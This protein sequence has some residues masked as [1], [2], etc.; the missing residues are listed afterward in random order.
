M[1]AKT[2]RA[3]RWLALLLTA[4]GIGV[5]SL[6][7]V[8]QPES[9][10][11]TAPEGV[12][13]TEVAKLQEKIS[14]QEND[15]D[16]SSTAIVFLTSDDELDIPALS[17]IAE[18]LGGPL[19][20]AESGRAAMVPVSIEAG[21]AT[22]NNEEVLQLRDDIAAELPE[23]VESQVTGP[24]A[25]R[26]DLAEVFQGANFLLLAVTAGIVAVL[27]IITYRSPIL[28]LLPLLVIAVA[29]RATNTVFTYLLDAMDF[30]WDESVAGI[31]S[32]LVFG[33]GTNY[34]LLLISRYRDELTL[35][36]DR[37]EAMAKAWIPTL[38]TVSASAGTV[39]LGVL[40]LLLSSVPT[41]QGL[42]VAAA[43][44]VSIAWIFALF[45]L[46]GV[47]VLF[48]RWIF[49]PRKPQYGDKQKAKVWD[50]IGNVVKS[51]PRVIGGVAFISLLVCCIGYFQTS[52]G[53]TQAEQFIDTPESIAAGEELEQEFPDQ[54]AT[55]PLVATQDPESTTATIEGM[56]ATVT[57]QGSADGWTLMQVSGAEFEE[58]RAEFPGDD[59]LVGGPA[60]DLADGEE[61]AADDRM[62]IFPLVL[63]LIFLTLIVMLRSLVAPIIMVA[64]VLLTNVAA[65][66]LGWWVSHYIL[67]FDSFDSSTPLYA[68]VFLVALGVDYTIFLI[69]RAREDA[70]EVG[71][72]RG[73]LTALSSTGG[74]ITSAGIVLAAVFSAL[75]VLPLVVLAQL[76]VTVF[77]G[78]LLDT[79]I[80][81]TILVPSVV[82]VI[83]EKFWWPAN[84]FKDAE[85]K[86]QA[87]L[88]ENPDAESTATPVKADS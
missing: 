46:P 28:W 23:G 88:K 9:A 16:Q 75:G 3:F 47:L 63:G 37:F 72:R 65:I 5:M 45:A 71:T 38:K 61:A 22:E 4:I 83:G 57:E 24:A 39:I 30:A 6:G 64:S 56:G 33:A 66:G 14:E 17:P 25:V 86:Y 62:L 79:L 77:I 76:G 58:L 49:W 18:Q 85:A 1:S 31:L 67:G 35:H 74:V 44:G 21:T 34:A 60:A 19:I 29:D 80:V 42:G 81:R 15:G 70:R 20:P 51:R 27:L 41:I 82:Q 73:I 10:T 52:T 54:S 69:T 8:D 48:G 87:S 11:A 50:R 53:L 40:C 13:A 84:P 59:V 7:G 78:V 55:P 36:E 12:K 2:M 26:A 68:F 43:I 32:V